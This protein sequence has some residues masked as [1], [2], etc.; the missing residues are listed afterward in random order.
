[1]AL[2]S[3]ARLAK[4]PSTTPIPVTFLDADL[5]ARIARFSVAVLRGGR[6]SEREVSLRSGAAMLAALRGEDLAGG[7]ESPEPRDACIDTPQPARVL[8]VECCADR[9]WKLEGVALAPG[10]C[11]QR[12]GADTLYLLAL[13]GGEGENGTIQGLLESHARVYTGSGVAASALCMNKHAT[14]LVLQHAGLAVAP[15]R[16]IHPLEWANDSVRVLSEI[17]GLSRQGWSVKPNCG[18]SS[19]STFLVATERELRPAIEAVLATGDRVLV[20]QR[21][22][23][24]EATCGVLGNER[25]RL[26]ALSP[27]EIVPHAGRFFDYE[28]KYSAGGAD[29]FCPPRAISARTCARLQELACTAH[30]AAGCD[31]YSRIDFIVPRADDG[32][33]GEPVVLEIN[34]LPGMTERSLL[35]KAAAAEGLALR[36]LL[37]EIA[38]LALVRWGTA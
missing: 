24:V 1:L 2:S 15:A 9:T 11:I 38:G 29:E 6:S 25:G 18:G 34:T 12:L 7:D 28:E 3:N 22:L 23:G 13:H 19:V 26:H 4:R 8:E 36:D 27:V 14:R 32:A 31:G 30:R 16:T 21:V 33:E 10:E 35:P 17:A 37:M 20:E 5:R